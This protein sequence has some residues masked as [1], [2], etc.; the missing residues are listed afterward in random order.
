MLNDGF[1]AIDVTGRW[2]GFYR[3]RWDALGTYPIVAE[4]FQSGS[5]VSGEMYD[6][7]TEHSAYFSEFIEVIERDIP[8]E[9]RRRMQQMVR[10][11]GPE[12]VRNARLPDAS[13][14]EGKVWGS[15][16]EFKKT[17][18]GAMEVSWS[19]GGVTLAAIRRDRHQVHYSGQLDRDRMCLTGKWTIWKRGLLGWLLPPD[20]RGTFELHRKS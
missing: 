8:D 18:R 20:A 14:I 3:Y 13:D 10:Q 5:T 11:F 4:L 15:H 6:Q 12:T 17:Y 19:V 2:I 1:D 7:I 16:L 9:T